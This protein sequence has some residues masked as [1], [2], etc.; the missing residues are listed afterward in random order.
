[1]APGPP[2]MAEEMEKAPPSTPLFYQN[3]LFWYN[4]VI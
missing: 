2:K 4:E 1:M 3:R